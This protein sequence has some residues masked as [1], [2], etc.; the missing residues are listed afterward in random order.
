M[1]ASGVG[2][3][4]PYCA[5]RG[6]RSILA[7]AHHFGT[8]HNIDD[9]LGNLRLELM[10][11]RENCPILELFDDRVVHVSVR[12]S[13]GHGR[14]RIH[15]VDILVPVD[16]PKPRPLGAGSKIWGH[17]QRVLGR[18][19]RE[20]LGA[21]RYG[22][23]R[24]FEHCLGGP[25]SARHRGAPATLGEGSVATDRASPSFREMPLLMCDSS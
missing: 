6:V 20:G 5:C 14:E 8:W 17:A 25:V 21:E 19:L 3:G 11:Q 18:A 24:P 7:K 15:E 13:Q 23:T 16:I 10:A 12:V 1:I 4:N 22:L 2:A 9:Q